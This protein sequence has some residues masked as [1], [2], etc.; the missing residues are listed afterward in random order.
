MNYSCFSLLTVT[1]SSFTATYIGIE[2][3]AH[4]TFPLHNIMLIKTDVNTL[5]E[6]PTPVCWEYAFF[7]THELTL[8][9]FGIELFSVAA[10][11]HYSS[12]VAYAD[13][14][15]GRILGVHDVLNWN[16]VFTFDGRAISGD[17]LPDAVVARGGVHVVGGASVGSGA[18]V[19]VTAVELLAVVRIGKVSL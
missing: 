18:E 8:G 6:F 13:A 15:Q 5:V 11:E 16:R 4:R 12:L 9:C 14:V 17:F 10:F 7:L 19:P 2:L 3:R 1:T